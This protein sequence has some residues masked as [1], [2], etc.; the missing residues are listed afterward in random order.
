[1]SVVFTAK[2]KRGG[3]RGEP[4]LRS[5]S[6][7]IGSYLDLPNRYDILLVKNQSLLSII[8]CVV[9]HNYEDLNVDCL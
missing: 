1:M 5:L 8:V 4:R 9:L 2:E 7:S 6:L 3:G